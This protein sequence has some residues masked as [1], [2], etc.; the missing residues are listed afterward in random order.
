LQLFGDGTQHLRPS[1]YRTGSGQE[2]QLDSRSLDDGLSKRKQTTSKRNYLEV[3]PNAL[4]I[5]QT[6]HSRSGFFK[7]CARDAPRQAGLGEA[8]HISGISMQWRWLLK[9]DYLSAS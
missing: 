1:Q 6:E 3:R 2:H 8:A 9:E 5:G 7:A 4:A